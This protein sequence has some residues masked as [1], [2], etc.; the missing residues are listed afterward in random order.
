[1]QLADEAVGFVCV[2]SLKVHL[3][4]EADDYTRDKTD[5]KDA[6]LI[7]AA[8]VTISQTTG[9]GAATR[10][11]PGASRSCSRVVRPQ[12][13]VA[14]RCSSGSATSGGIQPV[15]A[16]EVAVHGKRKRRKEGKGH[17]IGSPAA[18]VQ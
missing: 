18:A 1:M 16:A 10:A 12:D 13:G 11:C 8:P 17:I 6:V 15:M 2:R 5:H 7:P 9:R 14:P 3:A 4:R